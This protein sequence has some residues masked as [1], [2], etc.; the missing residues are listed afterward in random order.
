[1]GA[2]GSSPLGADPTNVALRTLRAI[3]DYLTEHRE[4]YRLASSG[5]SA[6]GLTGITDLLAW[7]VHSFRV[8]FGGDQSG[9]GEAETTAD[10]HMAAGMDG[11]LSAAVDGALGS[12]DA[13]IAE[14][15]FH[16]CRNG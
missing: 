12:D 3:L 15:L 6:T 14:M 1:M 8:E 9:S 4:L 11:V 13:R 2:L 5:R 16:C 10:V 7:Q